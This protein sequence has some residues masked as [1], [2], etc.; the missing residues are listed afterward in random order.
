MPK[1]KDWINPF[2][3]KNPL[4]NSIRDFTFG[5]PEKREN[6]STLRPE[7][8]DLYRQAVNAGM[9]PGAGGAF[10]TAADYYRNLL[11][12]NSADFDAFVTDLVAGA[13]KNKL[14]ANLINSVGKIVQTLRSQVVQ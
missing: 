11:S 7:Q 12:D 10:G 13:N 14:P 6:V 5:T 3:K 9:N 8:E 4:Q 1:F 2:S